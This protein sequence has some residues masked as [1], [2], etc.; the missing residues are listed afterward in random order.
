M[1]VRRDRGEPGDTC[2]RG[3]TRPRIVLVL[4]G[5]AIWLLAVA[6][7]YGALAAEPQ[8]RIERWD[9]PRRQW[10]QS[11]NCARYITFLPTRAARL[12]DFIRFGGRYYMRTGQDVAAPPN[13]DVTG[14]W[15]R[16][17]Q[18]RRLGSTLYV[19]TGGRSSVTPY[20]LGSCPG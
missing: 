20:T 5:V 6:G 19:Q 10:V 8:D 1:G 17:W 9:G 2:G 16:N 4:L 15:R 3:V 18:L 13:L 14:Y 7:A 11:G 12:P